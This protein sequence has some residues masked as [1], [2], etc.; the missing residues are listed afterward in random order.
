[1]NYLVVG[2]LAD[3]ELQT[4]ELVLLLYLQHQPAVYIANAPLKCSGC[5]GKK[6]KKRNIGTMNCGY[7]EQLLNGRA[8]MF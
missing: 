2:C 8:Q 7:E 4:R 3:K 5:G 6:K 1:M